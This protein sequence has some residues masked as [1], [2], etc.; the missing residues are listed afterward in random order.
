MSNSKYR[1]AF[2]L[3]H[4]ARMRQ[5]T[6]LSDHIEDMQ[7]KRIIVPLLAKISMGVTAPAYTPSPENV[8]KQDAIRELARYN[9]DEMT[10][11]ES[12]SYERDVLG[13]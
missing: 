10:Q 6:E 7:I 4:L 9:N 3:A 12:T 11:D 8:A 1:P 2:T 13:I 5:L